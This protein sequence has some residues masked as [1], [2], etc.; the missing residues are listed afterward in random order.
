MSI[1]V[2]AHRKAERWLKLHGIDE[3]TD[4]FGLI[5]LAYLDAYKDRS[6]PLP[7]KR[8]RNTG[9]VP[10]GLYR[11]WVDILHNNG[12]ITSGVNPLDQDW[13]RQG[14]P[15]SIDFWRKHDV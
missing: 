2:R 9:A 12:H 14:M 11:I 1:D 5:Y 3:E 15:E 13:Y 8:F 10:D 7:G 6:T 4:N